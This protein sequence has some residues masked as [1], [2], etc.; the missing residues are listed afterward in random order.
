MVERQSTG[1]QMART[2]AM[3][4]EKGSVWIWLIAALALAGLMVPSHAYI[5]KQRAGADRTKALGNVRQM[6]LSLFEF[7]AEFGRFPD[8]STASM[9]KE[10]T[11]TPLDLSGT[12]S[13]ALF[14]QLLA[15][16]LKSERPFY[17]RIQRSR[18][19]DDRFDDDAHALAPGECGFAYVAGL[20]GKNS[21]NT[22]LVLAPLVPGT[23]RFDP[24]PFGGYAVALF[25]DNSARPLPIDSNGSVLI[26]GKDLFDPS[27]PFWGGKAPNIKWQE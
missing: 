16:G 22:P 23:T 9:V 27:Q 2:P 21:P 4:A 5:R 25:L 8:E 24:V 18:K 20:S 12:S 15:Y 6:G 7:D 14:R 19:P 26:G 17:A 3:K 13:N 11:R 10:K 1:H